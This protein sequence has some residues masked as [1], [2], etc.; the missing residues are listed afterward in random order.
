MRLL[1]ASKSPARR[2]TFVAA[3]ITPIVRVSEVDEGA[4]LDSLTAGSAGAPTPAEQV[5]ALAEAKRD[6]V[7]SALD[8]P[9]A[10]DGPGEAD[11][12]ESLLLVACDSMLEI[13]GRMLGKP[14]SPEVAVERIR[15]MRGGSAVLRTGH[16]LALLRL[17]PEGSYGLESA[18]SRSASTI[19]HFGMM[20]DAEIDAY[21]ESG[22]P[23]HVAGSFTI[24]GLGGPFITGVEGD[25]HSV[26]G[27]SLPLVHDL[28]AELGVFWPDLWD[29]RRPR[30]RAERARTGARSE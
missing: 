23:L 14:R 28:A 13:N 2:A 29:H 24:D 11:G 12:A 30:A 3:G 1:L 27:V 9:A 19:V 18:V 16:A 25:H 6:A 5:L 21:V 22:E 4:V 7:V 15:E 26:V 17:G 10:W 20:S 8:S